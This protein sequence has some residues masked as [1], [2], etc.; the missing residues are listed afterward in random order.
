LYNEFDK[1]SYNH[2]NNNNCYQTEKI[3]IYERDK[4]LAENNMKA[5]DPFG[6]GAN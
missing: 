1:S 6:F 5:L 2:I 3:A 4:K